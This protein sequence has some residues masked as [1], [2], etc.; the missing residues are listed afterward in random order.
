MF[1]Y[2]NLEMCWDQGLMISI[3]WRPSFSRALLW[4]LLIPS[5]SSYV[6]NTLFRTIFLWSPGFFFFFPFIYRKAL[7]SK[8]TAPIASKSFIIITYS[9]FRIHPVYFLLLSLNWSCSVFSLPLIFTIVFLSKIICSL[10]SLRWMSLLLRRILGLYTVSCGLVIFW[11]KVHISNF[12]HEW[13]SEL[14][15][16]GSSHGC[17]LL[18]GS[19]E[20]SVSLL[21]LAIVHHYASYSAEKCLVQ[22]F[23]Y[24]F[25]IKFLQLNIFSVCGMII[26]VSVQWFY[27]REVLCILKSQSLSKI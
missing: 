7:A 22:G 2:L 4:L 24:L 6:G 19:S 20:L 14:S 18:R 27:L 16:A 13:T 11:V 10:P 26:C 9:I 15:R 23:H 3:R 12:H 5:E 17:D 1:F 21:T 25:F 8:C